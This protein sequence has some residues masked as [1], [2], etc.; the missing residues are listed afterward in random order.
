MDVHV[1]VIQ[2]H[3]LPARVNTGR[4]PGSWPSPHLRHT[5]SFQKNSRSVS[6]FACSI[7]SPATWTTHTSPTFLPLLVRR[8]RSF[9]LTNV[10][11]NTKS[12][13]GGDQGKWKQDARSSRGSWE[14]P[15]GRRHQLAAGTSWEAP[16]SRNGSTYST[17][18]SCIDT[19]FYH[20]RAE[21]GK[22]QRSPAHPPRPP[23]ACDLPSRSLS[24]SCTLNEKNTCSNLTVWRTGS[25]A[26]RHQ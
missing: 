23:R 20:V 2:S 5:G 9:S 3:S 8:G 15:G 11:P 24:T 26:M 19:L 21:S 17:C 6:D 16:A 7:V 13:A 4:D 10:Q 1:S 25:T 14:G 18:L 22:R 12:A